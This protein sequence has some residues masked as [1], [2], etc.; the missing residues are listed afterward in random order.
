MTRNIRKR[1]LPRVEG[2]EDRC[3]TTALS[4]A[5]SP[6]TRSAV[7]SRAPATLNQ[8]VLAYARS[9]LGRRVGD[10]ECATLAVQALASARARGLVEPAAAN[11]DYTW[12]KKVAMLTPTH[13][14]TAAI[15]PGDILQLRD[16]STL[17]VTRT[18]QP[19]G[20]VW[21]MT[22]TTSAQHHTAI[23]A[24]VSGN[25][26]K[27]YEQNVGGGT[28]AKVVQMGTLNLNDLRQGTIGVYRPVAR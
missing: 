3:L 4:A 2:I 13:H 14:S 23:V 21:T 8:K 9:Q 10:G 22:R 7:V 6:V 26:I 20:S 5:A 15:Q 25:T 18:Q 1:F 27:V 11:S 12:G 16:V 19:D 28:G 24:S 17:S